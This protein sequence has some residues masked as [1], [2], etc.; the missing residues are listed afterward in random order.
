M[1]ECIIKVSWTEMFIVN[2]YLF[3]MPEITGTETMI[4]GCNLESLTAVLPLCE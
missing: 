2:L 3:L 1:N 4:Y